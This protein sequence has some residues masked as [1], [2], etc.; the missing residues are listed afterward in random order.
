M[1]NNIYIC[2]QKNHQF[3]DMKT[4]E[5]RLMYQIEKHENTVKGHWATGIG[6]WELDFL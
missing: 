3:S 5:E 6:Y 2:N 4:V 1:T